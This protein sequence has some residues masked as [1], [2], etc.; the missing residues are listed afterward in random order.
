MKFCLNVLTKINEIS[1]TLWKMSFIFSIVQSNKVNYHTIN[2]SVQ[3]GWSYKLNLIKSFIL[4]SD[5]LL[6]HAFVKNI[7][8]NTVF[9]ANN[10]SLSNRVHHL[11]KVWNTNSVTKIQITKSS[12]S[13]N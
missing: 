7:C 6:L 9:W 3:F 1:V 8:Q 13:K 4:S 12:T 11:K 2:I 10:R 5:I